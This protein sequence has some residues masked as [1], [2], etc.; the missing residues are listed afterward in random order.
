[1]SLETMTEGFRAQVVRAGD[2]WLKQGRAV[3]ATALR[4]G[5]RTLA[6]TAQR[7]DGLAERLAPVGAVEG[8]T[9][10]SKEAPQE[11][12]AEAPVAAPVEAVVTA[13]EVVAEAAVVEVAEAAVV[14]AAAVPEVAAVAPAE[15]KAAVGATADAEAKRRSR[16]HGRR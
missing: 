9:E 13:P 1:M 3:G 12:A 16:R 4:T 14:E 6:E 7:L 8:G 11:I 15:V 5:A 10:V 2:G